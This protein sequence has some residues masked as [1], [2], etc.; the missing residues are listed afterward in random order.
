[1]TIRHIKNPLAV[2]KCKNRPDSCCPGQNSSKS[3][4]GGGGKRATLADAVY[5]TCDIHS[6][7]LDWAD[8][9]LS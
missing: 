7:M 4:M 8:V 5:A 3:T 2:G 9:G 6:E 1:M